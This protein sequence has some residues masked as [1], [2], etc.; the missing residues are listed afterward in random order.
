MRTLVLV[1]LLFVGLLTLA[2]AGQE[3]T[4]RARITCDAVTP[5]TLSFPAHGGAQEVDVAGLCVWE[6]VPTASA[7][8]WVTIPFVTSETPPGGNGP[9]FFTVAVARNSGPARRGLIR[10]GGFSVVITQRKGKR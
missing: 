8:G 5:L 2:V 4:L 10:V 3:Q 7:E 1:V 6:P 9:G